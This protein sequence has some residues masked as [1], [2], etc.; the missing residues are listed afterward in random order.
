VIFDSAP[1]I[2]FADTQSLCTKVDG[3]ILVVNYD[4]TR[5]QVALRAKKELEE[6]GANILGVI[7]NRRKYYIPDWIYRRL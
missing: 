5:R 3:V 7:I 4:K 1:V 6:A 2:G